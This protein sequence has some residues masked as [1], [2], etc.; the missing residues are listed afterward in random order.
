MLSFGDK[1][2]QRSSC[3]SKTSYN[4]SEEEDEKPLLPPY[5]LVFYNRTL[6]DKPLPPLPSSSQHVRFVI[7][8]PLPP[9]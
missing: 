5:G 8:K 2:S 3:D 7:E 4:S 6:R 9:L 1:L